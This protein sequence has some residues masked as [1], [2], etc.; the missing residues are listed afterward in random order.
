MILFVLNTSCPST[1]GLV[2]NSKVKVNVP[3][4]DSNQSFTPGPAV[5]QHE[6]KVGIPDCDYS[7]LSTSNLLMPNTKSRVGMPDCDPSH[8][9]T[10]HPIIPNAKAKINN[11][12]FDTTDSNTFAQ[13]LKQRL[14]IVAH[15]A[16]DPGT[17]AFSLT[18]N[19]R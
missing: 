16:G 9:G 14:S 19:Q 6:A 13:T 2:Q 8:P 3:G 10:I 17:L 4:C 5:F 15:D 18:L 1:I 7:H 12:D 11:V